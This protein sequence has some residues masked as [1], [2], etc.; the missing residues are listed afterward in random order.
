MQ[1][2]KKS[3]FLIGEKEA[4]R[5]LTAALVFSINPNRLNGENIGN[6]AC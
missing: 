1:E 5:A 4:E 2:L 6:L 3:H